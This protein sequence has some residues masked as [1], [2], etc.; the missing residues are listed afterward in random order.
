MTV[1]CPQKRQESQFS[2]ISLIQLACS[3]DQQAFKT[4]M[5]RYYI[6]VLRHIKKKINNPSDAED[7]VQQ[8]FSKAF[9]NIASYSS[10]YAFSTWLYTIAT[11]CCIDFL[12]KKKSNK[13]ISIDQLIE[14]DN[15]NMQA[16]Q[17]NPEDNLIA[18]QNAE[19]VNQWMTM[20][21][22]QYQQ[23]LRLRYIC[24][25]AYD[26]IA[27]TLNIPIGT[28]KTLLFRAKEQMLKLAVNKFL[29]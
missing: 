3:E 23:V 19:V 27:T 18:K 17:L 2:D 9:S 20:L 26:E 16:P 13:T 25:C 12:R 15:F 14:E 11:H 7:I 6:G 8:T 22:P 10:N 5:D 1:L 28:V 29:S 4:L 24:G 21:K